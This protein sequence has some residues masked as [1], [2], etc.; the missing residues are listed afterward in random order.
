[1]IDGRDPNQHGYLG[2]SYARRGEGGAT[3]RRGPGGT[4]LHAIDVLGIL[5]DPVQRY[6]DPS[7]FPA[8]VDSRGG[9][10]APG[11]SVSSKDPRT[12]D[13][14]L[15]IVFG[16][17]ALLREVRWAAEDREAARAD[18]LAAFRGGA[19]RETLES[20]RGRAGN[21]DE[22]WAR[23]ETGRAAYLAAL[24]ELGLGHGAD[25][26][27]LSADPRRG[28][29]DRVVMAVLL[30]LGAEGQDARLR[31]YEEELRRLAAKPAA[32]SDDGV[33]AAEAALQAALAA[34]RAAREAVLAAAPVIPGASETA[35]RLASL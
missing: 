8:V 13:G 30:E 29:V 15:N 17:G 12:L 24:A 19:R 10:L 33:A 31:V 32:A 34:R 25:G 27:S 23:T 11:E 20:V 7:Q 9:A 22:A 35:A 16:S 28:A 14:R 4:L 18:A 26:G 2:R 6:F 5:P 3:I 21:Y 1:M